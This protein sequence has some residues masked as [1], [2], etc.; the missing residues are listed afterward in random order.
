MADPN[1][2]IR[3]TNAA[4]FNAALAQARAGLA[5]PAA[6][7]NA[8]ARELTV[9]AAAAAPRRSGRLAGAHRALPATGKRVAI[10]A[11]TPYAAALHWGWPE[12]NIARRPWLVATWLRNPKPLEKAGEAIQAGLDKA[13]AR[14]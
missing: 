6:P 11:D 10:V 2:E 5:E 12:H 1:L 8:A 3:V 13:A 7:L 9:A 14:T 4:A